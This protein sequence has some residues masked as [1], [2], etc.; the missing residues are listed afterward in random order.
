MKLREFN[1]LTIPEMIDVSESKG[2]LISHRKNDK[3]IYFLYHLFSFYTE[4]Q[5]NSETKI[6]TKARGFSK[7]K[8]LEP[9][10]KHITLQGIEHFKKENPN[11]NILP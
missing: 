3:Y 4:L 11:W 5:Y 7:L 2:V 10:I 6:Y 9:Y 1:K 8:L